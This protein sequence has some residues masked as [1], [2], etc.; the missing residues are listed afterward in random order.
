MR[1][2]AVLNQPYSREQLAQSL[3]LFERALQ[4][5]PELPKALVGLAD[6]LAMQVNARWTDTPAEQ[7]RRADEAVD[8]VLAVFH[9]DAMA[10]FVKGEIQRAKGRNMEVAIGEDDAAIA[11][12]PSL[13]PAYGSL[14][15]ALIRAGRSP[16]A[17]APLNMAIRLSPRDPL[18][19]LWYFFIC[20]AHT[21]LEQYAST[22]DWCT[23][24][25]AVKP[26][27]IAYADLAAA[28]ALTGRESEAHAA[29]TELRRLMPDYTVGR[30]ARDGGGW[31]DNVVF[32]AQFARMTDGLRKAGL[33]E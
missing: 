5:D 10:H 33:P 9:D 32:L 31:S 3:G 2:W 17:F 4:I 24:S 23:K 28:Y 7:L 14:G 18:L 12:N 16:E 26:F 27:W 30:W 20:H 29:V 11:I 21:H 8:R 1:G 22:I 6:A 25:I 13:S 15:I 19:N